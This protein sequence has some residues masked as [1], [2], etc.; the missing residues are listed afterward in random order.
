MDR[1]VVYGFSTEGYAIAS[2]MVDRGADV[3]IVDESTGSA[4]SLKPEIAKTYPDV[5]SL[6]E[7]EPLM[8]VEPLKVAVAQAKYLFFAPR[9]RRAGAEAKIEINAKFKDATSNLAEDSAVICNI[10]AGLG[11][12]SEYISLLRHVTGMDVGRQVAYYYYPL[13]ERSQPN[14]IG[15]VNGESDPLLVSLLS[16]GDEKRFVNIASAEQAHTVDVLTRF[17]RTVSIIEVYKHANSDSV[18]E[19]LYSDAQKDMFLDNMISGLF[20]LRLINDSQEDIKAVQYLINGSIRG[21]EGYIKR[22]VDTIR[23]TLKDNGLK[24]S[25]T[26]I[27]IAWSLD[28]HGMRGDKIEAFQSLFSRLQ[29]YTGKVDE[30]AGL[31]NFHTDKTTLVVACS[32]YDYDRIREMQH[33][34]DNT[35][36][37]KATPLIET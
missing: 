11:G 13:E 25:R 15:A 19:D 1:V 32:R 28:Q 22:L 7:D 10:P 34:E 9:I 2:H 6:L 30:Y 31:Q 37:I 16:D 24:V 5:A 4:I 35:I 33:D 26:N 8:K 23:S 36:I 12:N 29:D 3:Y 14:V 20:D 27:A 18:I 17:S 21:I